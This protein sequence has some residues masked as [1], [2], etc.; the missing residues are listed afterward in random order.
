M[1]AL[2]NSKI[3][4]LCRLYWSCSREVEGR[5]RLDA[6]SREVGKWEVG[7]W[8]AEAEKGMRVEEPGTLLVLLDAYEVTRDEGMLQR[9]L[10][11][12]GEGLERLPVSAESV[13]LLAYCYYYVENGEC[14]S[15]AEEMLGRLEEE[16]VPLE[17]LERAAE[18]LREFA[19]N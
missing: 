13:K 16:G 1:D 5:V 2:I 19:G 4:S 18:G 8:C 14:L 11:V 3:M 6:I 10:D 9:V 7:K 17:E 15:R 12:V